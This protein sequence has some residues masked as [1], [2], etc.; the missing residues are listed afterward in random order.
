MTALSIRQPWAWLIAAGHKDV[1]NRR[2]RTRFRGEFLIHAS[3]GMTEEEY[4]N[5]KNFLRTKPT[6]W[7][8]TFDNLKR[9]GIIGRAEIVDCVM[10]SDS[11]WFFGPY[12]FV[13]RNAVQLPFQ[14]CKGQLRFFEP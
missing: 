4:L 12:G 8:P 1:E 9:G 11:P 6:V 7:L 10:E 13:I 5:V 3:Q 14:P 2:W